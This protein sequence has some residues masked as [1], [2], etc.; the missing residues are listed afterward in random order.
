M[1]SRPKDSSLDTRVRKG[2]IAVLSIELAT[3]VHELCV[4]AERPSRPQ[5][6]NTA[7]SGDSRE[8]EEGL[9]R[10]KAMAETGMCD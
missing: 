1:R 5:P 2:M 3:Y 4:V 9:G 10:I 7:A 8:S 6:E